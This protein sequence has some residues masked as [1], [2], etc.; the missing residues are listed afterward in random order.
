MN[1]HGVGGVAPTYGDDRRSDPRG[2]PVVASPVGV[3]TTIVRPDENGWLADTPEQWAAAIRRLAEDSVLRRR[4]GAAG[5]RQ[6]EDTY[7]LQAQ[8]GRLIGMLG[9]VVETA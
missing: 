7:S 1:V 9:G 5:R 2:L 4:M 8:A 3:N 6:V